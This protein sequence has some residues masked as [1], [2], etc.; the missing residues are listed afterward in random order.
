MDPVTLIVTALTAGAALVAQD[1]VSAMVTDAYAGLKALVKKRLGGRPGAELVLAGHEQAPERWQ[2][3][4][5]AE[6]AGSGADGDR[7]L[8]TAAQALLDLVGEA[9]GQTGK[10]TVD[11]RSARG[12]QIGDHNRQDNV[13]NVPPG[14]G[15]TVSAKPDPGD[16]AR[17][18]GQ[19]LGAGRF[20]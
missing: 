2:A 10:Y 8:I 4:L 5:M 15:A 1:A 3:L 9:K 13:F 11:A 16:C 18:S 12:V 17:R 14:L 7:D 6:L 20:R 19:P